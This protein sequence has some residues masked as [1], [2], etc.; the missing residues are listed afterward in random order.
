MDFDRKRIGEILVEKGLITSEQ[1]NQALKEQK[2]SQHRLLGAIL[3]ER[4]FVTEESLTKI[5]KEVDSIPVVDL[6][7]MKDLDQKV[8]QSIP[9]RLARRF[10][11]IAIGKQ[12]NK[13]L[14]AMADPTDVR[15]LDLV[16]VNTG[17]EVL[18]LRAFP[19]EISFA[20]DKYYSHLVDFK[21]LENVMGVEVTPAEE[22]VFDPTQLKV[23]AGD[24][25]IVKFVN[26][27]L[28]QAIENRASDLHLEPAVDKINVRLR[29][30][31]ILF[32]AMAP[33]RNTY[34]AIIS[35]IKIISG[36]DIAE[37][38]LPQD[39]RC[40][41]KIG[42]KEIDVRI[43][44]IPTMYGEK[45]VLRLLDKTALVSLPLVELGLDPEDLE[46]FKSILG[47][48]YGMILVTGPTGSG[49][50]TTLYTGLNYIN[51]PKKNLMTV[52]DPVEYELAGVNQIQVRP[53]IGL[54]FARI[55]RH[56]LRQD[57]DIIMV[58]EIRDL[59]TARIAITVAL[60]GHLV[61]STL[62]T[63]NAP[64]AIN[65]LIQMGVEPFLI[66]AS[67]NL[68]MAQRLVRRL[69]EECKKEI[70]LPEEVRKK[71]SFPE[72][73]KLYRGAGCKK[74]NQSGYFGRIGLFEFMEVDTR[75]KNLILKEE[76][77]LTIKEEARKKGMKTL[78]E[79]GFLKV[80]R[81]ITTLEEV[82]SV[83][84]EDETGT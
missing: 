79:S 11:L 53:Q 56:I 68:V 69:C 76:N 55:L 66:S 50:T 22:E 27:L 82:L 23:A 83:T 48:A 24:T 62:H 81:G 4:G 40:K 20:L 7:R 9:E 61:F 43:S 49:K 64:A 77:E 28:F 25:P 72:D 18:P 46:K 15:A 16:Q 57:P 10:S 80:R 52:E 75:I 6:S 60:T 19:A 71:F 21:E 42:S 47:Q 39:G 29:I 41:I 70:S 73:T 34:P 37:R 14:V 13:L 17:C 33:P 44:T 5:I 54:D 74:C 51:T 32:D 36:L 63:N 26:A 65:R 38:R 78:R 8:V 12:D 58:G 67:L 35:R 84:L 59:E 3:I 2:K 1:L 30:D 45:V 31:G